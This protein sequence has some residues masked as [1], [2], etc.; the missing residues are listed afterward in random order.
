MLDENQH[1]DFFFP[2]TG[3]GEISPVP[4]P[5][6]FPRYRS[7]RNFLGTGAGEIWP[8]LQIVCSAHRIKFSNTKESGQSAWYVENGSNSTS[9]WIYFLHKRLNFS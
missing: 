3:A 2:G 4:E 1:F 7:R 8:V 9:F 6:K 5:A